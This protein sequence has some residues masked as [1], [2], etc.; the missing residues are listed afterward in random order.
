[1]AATRYVAARYCLARSSRPATT[2]V[3]TALATVPKAYE[4]HTSGGSSHGTAARHESGLSCRDWSQPSSTFGRW[5]ATAHSG[6]QSATLAHPH[7]SN[8]R[9]VCGVKAARLEGS[10]RAARSLAPT[11]VVMTRVPSLR[12]GRRQLCEVASSERCRDETRW[13]GRGSVVAGL[14]TIRQADILDGHRL[15]GHLAQQ[16]TDEVEPPTP[17]A[18]G[19]DDVPRG[20]RGVGRREHRVPGTGVVVPAAVGLEVHVRQLPDLAGIVDAALDAAGLFVGADL[21]PVL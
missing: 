13:E 14:L 6:R 2:R 4:T 9:R 8:R 7:S 12:R 10:G 20:P 3:A 19:V 18:V 21:Q 16:V 1:M 17:L 15:V 5:T 11:P